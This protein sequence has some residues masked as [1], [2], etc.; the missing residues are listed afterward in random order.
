MRALKVP[1]MT[2][3]IFKGLSKSFK[4]NLSNELETTKK[5]W[6]KSIQLKVTIAEILKNE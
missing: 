2:K 6:M 4:K 1:I 5:N 3:L